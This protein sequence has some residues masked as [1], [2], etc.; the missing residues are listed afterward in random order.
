[1]K[2]FLR[3]TGIVSLALMSILFDIALTVFFMPLI[4]IIVTIGLSVVFTLATI[5]MASIKLRNT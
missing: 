5:N 4:A 1:M 2:R 3:K